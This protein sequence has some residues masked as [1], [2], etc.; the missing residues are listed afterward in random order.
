M[1]RI[2]HGVYGDEKATQ[3]SKP[4][5]TTTGIQFIVGAAPIHRLANPAGAVN[6]LFMLRSLDE[7]KSQ[8]GYNE[9]FDKFDL[10]QSMYMDFSVRKVAPAIF[11]NVLDPATHKTAV[12]A[13]TCTVSNGQAKLQQKYMLIDANL[14]VK[15]GEDTLVRG[16]DYIAKHDEDDYLVITLLLDTMPESVSVAGNKLNPDAVTASDIVGG[17]DAST[18]V[19]TGLSLINKVYPQFNINANLIICPKWSKNPTVA[20]AMAALCE[21]ISGVFR[22]EC[23]IDIP[24][25]RFT[26]YSDADDMKAYMGVKSEHANFVWP[27]AKIGSH[28]IAGSVDKAAIAQYTDYQNDG[29]PNVSDSNE[30]AY[31]DA[32]VLEDGT[33]VL[34]TL[35]EANVL[36]G[37]A[38]T[39][40]LKVGIWRVWGN[41]SAAYPENQDP[42]D[43]WWCIRRFFSWHD[44]NFIRNYFDLVDD[45]TNPKL[46]DTVIDS[47]NRV[48]NGYTSNGQCAMASIVMSDKNT[49]ESIAAGKMLFDTVMTPYPPAQEI[50]NTTSFN[51]DALAEALTL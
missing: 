6:K 19:T 40:F 37:S 38:I 51:P 1:E 9:E 35:D 44:N 8:L 36:N 7:A 16:T 20:A 34:L 45:P 33:E 43:M 24:T 31:I 26:K 10:C 50:R 12:E 14:I 22:A 42:K 18:G 39:T 41:Y 29:V 47:E 30:P 23:I 4:V 48:L 27:M 46:R 49:A 21:E 5:E 3:M 11:V 25:D 28:I 13:T 2:N 15:N 32:A 17:T